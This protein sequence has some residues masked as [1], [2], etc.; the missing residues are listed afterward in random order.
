MLDC[1][2]Y[3][4]RSTFGGAF[5]KPT[6]VL[7]IFRYWYKNEDLILN[8]RKTLTKLNYGVFLNDA[9]TSKTTTKKADASLSNGSLRSTENAQ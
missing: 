3:V 2:N 8:C 6:Y 1:R 4:V 5:D 7:N 9:S